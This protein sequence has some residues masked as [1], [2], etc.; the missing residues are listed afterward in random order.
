MSKCIFGPKWRTKLSRITMWFRLNM[1]IGFVI[2]CIFY[3]MFWFLCNKFGT[4]AVNFQVSYMNCM[5]LMF[6]CLFIMLMDALQFSAELKSP[7]SCLVS[8]ASWYRDRNK[9]IDRKG[10][11]S[12]IAHYANKLWFKHSICTCHGC[13]QYENLIYFIE[14]NISNWC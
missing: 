2:T 5:L 6:L 14:C 10:N 9:G 11:D 13:L 7:Y 12:V 4:F 3:M 1:T 8:T